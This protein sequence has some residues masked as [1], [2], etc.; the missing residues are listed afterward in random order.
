LKAIEGAEKETSMKLLHDDFF[1]GLSFD[2]EDEGDIF[3]RNIHGVS[4]IIQQIYPR[5]QTLNSIKTVL[6]ISL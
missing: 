4:R 6:T 2:P 1:L 3:F 5:N